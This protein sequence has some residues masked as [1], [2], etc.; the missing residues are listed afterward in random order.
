MIFLFSSSQELALRHV[1]DLAKSGQL[2]ECKITLNDLDKIEIVKETLD[3]IVSTARQLESNMEDVNDADL[4]KMLVLKTLK[5]VKSNKPPAYE[6]LLTENIVD[7]EEFE[8][9]VDLTEANKSV[10][11][12]NLSPPTSAAKARPQNL[13]CG[14]CKIRQQGRTKNIPKDDSCHKKE[15][16]V[17][18]CKCQ[19][20][21]AK[22][23]KNT[24]NGLC[25]CSN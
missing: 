7:S 9:F 12:V 4:I 21:N 2:S 25:F 20:V 19:V 14:F 13:E 5:Q 23:A 3:K 16:A 11:L 24:Q 8:T 6:N 10:H 15:M 22:K 18:V 17:I 1:K